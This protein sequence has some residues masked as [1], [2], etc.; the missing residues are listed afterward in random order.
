[1]VGGSSSPFKDK[2][3]KLETVVDCSANTLSLVDTGDLEVPI[4]IGSGV[5]IASDNVLGLF[6]SS[7]APNCHILDLIEFHLAEVNAGL[8]PITDFSIFAYDSN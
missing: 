8:A 1:M 7:G 2:E 6:E 4:E 5:T 3:I